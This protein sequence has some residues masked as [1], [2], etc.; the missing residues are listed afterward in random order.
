MA[1]KKQF[2]AEEVAQ[3]VK[4]AQGFVTVAARALGCTT[5]TIHNYRNTYKLVAE[6]FDE[7]RETHLDFVEG[8][9]MQQIKAGNIAGIIFYLKTQGRTRGYIERSQVEIVKGELQAMLDLLEKELPPEEYDHVLAVL[10]GA[11]QP[12]T[13]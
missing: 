8:K 5:R 3:A 13:D 7:S 6:A 9:L 1:R 2:T 12:Q 11:G 10:A 4:K